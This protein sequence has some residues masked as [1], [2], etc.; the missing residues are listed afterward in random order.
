MKGSERA[1]TSAA[2]VV[3]LAGSLFDLYEFSMEGTTSSPGGAG[4]SSSINNLVGAISTF[5][6]AQTV[7]TTIIA[8]TVFA[9]STT[10]SSGNTSTLCT[11]VY[12]AGENT[13]FLRVVSDSNQTPVVGARVTATHNVTGPTCYGSVQTT[14]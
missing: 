8:S 3:L 4:N 14:T 11:V 1:L 13:L 5:T 6:T 2:V 7:H 12:P 9:P 10:T